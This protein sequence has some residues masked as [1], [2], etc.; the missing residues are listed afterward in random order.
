MK[1][2]VEDFVKKVE[3]ELEDI[4][5]GSLKPTTNYRDIES[6]SS[7][8][9]LIII[10]LVSTEYNRTLTGEDLKKCNTFS[11]LYQVVLAKAD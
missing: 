5:S 4:P 2:S 9:A 10:A 1:D 6:W 11:D 7:M 8:Y 3:N